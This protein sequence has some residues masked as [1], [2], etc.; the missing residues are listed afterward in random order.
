[1]CRSWFGIQRK[2]IG[3][4]TYIAAYLDYLA[5]RNPIAVVKAVVIDMSTIRVPYNSFQPSKH[6]ESTIYLSPP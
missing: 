3:I 1:M 6:C 5:L 2:R 4:P